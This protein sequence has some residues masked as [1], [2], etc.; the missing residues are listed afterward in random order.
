MQTVCRSVRIV[1]IE[2]KR[3]FCKILLER[4][5]IRECS[6]QRQAQRS[7]Q[8]D[9]SRKTSPTL[10][11][12]ARHA[13]VSTMTVSRVLNSGDLVK[14]ATREKVMAAIK[15]LNYAPNIMARRLAGGRSVRMC[16][17]YANPSSA[18]LG[19]LLIGAL[20]V[21]SG[22][23]HQLIVE[24]ISETISP[25]N[26]LDGLDVAW[27][28]VIVPPPLSDSVE[29]RSRLQKSGA[30][31]VYLSS[32]KP[33]IADDEVSIDDYAAARDMT[34]LLIERGHTRIGM[35]KG[36]PN[37][38]VSRRRLRGFLHEMEAAGVPVEDKW[39]EQGYF[40]YRSGLE[41]GE[42]I[43]SRSPRPTAVFA[44]NDDMAAGLLR[45]AAQL[46]LKAPD[47]LSVCGFDDSPIATILWPP[48]TT[49]RQP[50]AEMA[51]AA[52]RLLD[53]HLDEGGGVA[54]TTSSFRAEYTVCSRDSVGP[55]SS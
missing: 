44:A 32:V 38:S 1:S 17:L 55:P 36:H 29:L 24:R 43:L 23:G 5:Q 4:S 27:D 22:L 25:P 21:A 31:A 46:G 53:A 49:V 13:G 42:A 12:V 54:A 30:P 11:D 15:A 45:A 10:S 52:V 8:S 33:D 35:I 20:E 18:Y 39:I 37:Q 16:L 51:G 26:A 19:E 41:A 34:R 48:L 3:C 7:M 14:P 47:D 2:A 9:R 40:T 6:G 28:G 50:V